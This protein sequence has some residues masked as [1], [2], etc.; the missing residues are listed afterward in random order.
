[1]EKAACRH[2]GKCGG[3]S[4][5]HISISEQRKEK[6]RIVSE[7]LQRAGTPPGRDIEVVGGS[8]Y[9]YRT[10]MDFAVTPTGLALR[11]RGKW[12][13][14]VEI[15]E[16]PIANK[17]VAV[18]MRE[19]SSWLRENKRISPFNLATQQGT[20]RYAVIRH[21]RN[22]ASSCVSFA[23]NRD[24]ETLAHDLREVISFAEKA[25]AESVVVAYTKPKSDQSVSQDCEIVKGSGLLRETLLGKSFH[26]HSQGFF[27]NNPEVF[28]KLL[29]F[30]LEEV[31]PGKKL[32]ELYGGAGPIA[33]TLSEKF[34][35]AVTADIEDAAV[36]LA[37]RNIRNNKA[38]NCSALKIDASRLGAEEALLDRETT[39]VA[40]PPRQGLHPRLVRAI[41]EKRPQVIAYV[42]C[43]PS[44][45]ARDI[46]ALRECYGL[47]K[48]RVFDMF[49]QTAHV[50]AVAILKRI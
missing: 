23:L 28:E 31:P 12:H 5:Q 18:L 34:S 30:L 25:S 46:S 26:Y 7:H 42:S 38:G 29:S 32:L 16:C 47:S 44:S 10:R 15:S 13:S 4:L 39:L 6:A 11:E 20:L 43:N 3:C 35:S 2:F 27:Q 40:D 49:P 37:W 9:G 14:L 19:V 45:M 33:I 8:P 36:E 21:A 50:E 1:M 41:R 17:G 22:T 48:I 24:S